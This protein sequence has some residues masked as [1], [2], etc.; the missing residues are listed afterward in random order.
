MP[1]YYNSES[2]FHLPFSA[3]SIISGRK[4]TLLHD[5]QRPF[6]VSTILIKLRR[7]K[8]NTF[9]ITSSIAN[10]YTTHGV[11]VPSLMMGRGGR[12]QNRPANG[13]AEVPA[14]C[15]TKGIIFRHLLITWFSIPRQIIKS[16]R[17]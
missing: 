17:C 2:I 16:G 15:A 6:Y 4:K 3:P 10:S 14:G 5:F 11:S 9:L 1:T 8:S 7:T 13:D 12:G